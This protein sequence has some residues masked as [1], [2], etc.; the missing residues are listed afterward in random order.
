MDDYAG[1][2]RN[3][4]EEQTQKGILR[5]FNITTQHLTTSTGHDIPENFISAI[6]QKL[7]S[8]VGKVVYYGEYADTGQVIKEDGK[9][10]AIVPWYR[11]IGVEE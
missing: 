10:Y 4:T 3:T 8:W 2:V 9:E 1:I 7:A 11:L 6:D 5:S